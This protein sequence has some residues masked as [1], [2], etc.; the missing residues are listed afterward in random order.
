MKICRIY[1]GMAALMISMTGCHFDTDTLT[2]SVLGEDDAIIDG[3]YLLPGSADIPTLSFDDFAHYMPDSISVDHL[4]VFNDPGMVAAS[5]STSPVPEE[6]IIGTR[7]I[8]QATCNGPPCKNDQLTGTAV[9]VF[10]PDDRIISLEMIDL[11]SADLNFHLHGNLTARSDIPAVADA[12]AILSFTQGSEV[13]T[14]NPVAG[15]TLDTNTLAIP[16]TSSIPDTSGVSDP[17]LHFNF[18]YGDETPIVIQGSGLPV[19]GN[20]LQ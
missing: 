13:F 3:E 11:S 14:I 7:Y 4:E 1:P 10:Y 2:Y 17:H 20:Q 19:P 6:D 9:L 12:S 5:L 15:F 8:L 18:Q 16:D